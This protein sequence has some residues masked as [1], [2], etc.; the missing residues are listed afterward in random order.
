ME[1]RKRNLMINK[2]DDTA[3]K[4][5]LNYRVSLPAPWIEKMG[6]SKE[7]RKLILTFD[8]TKII[9]E[10]VNKNESNSKQRNIA[11]RELYKRKNTIIFR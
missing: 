7:N 8:G 4:E 5:S 10:K 3:G 2:A 6:L 9:I 11:K 1:I